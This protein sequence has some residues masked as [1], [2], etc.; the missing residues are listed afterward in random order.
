MTAPYITIPAVALEAAARDLYVE[1]MVTL[2][3]NDPRPFDDLPTHMQ[4]DYRREA[5][6]ACLAVLRAWPG[7]QDSG[8][9][10]GKHSTRIYILPLPTENTDAEG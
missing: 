7:A 4:D 8:L 3:V 6:A 10:M 2:C 5:R 9:T 1:L